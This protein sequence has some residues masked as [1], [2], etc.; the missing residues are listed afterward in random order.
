MKKW[1]R[2]IKLTDENMHNVV[3]GVEEKAEGATSYRVAK[4]G[5]FREVQFRKR[6][7]WLCK[8]S[9][10]QRPSGQTRPPCKPLH[11]DFGKEKRC[12]YRVWSARR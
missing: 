11:C 1:G 5:C 12:R 3:G 10:D 6:K 9:D 7:Q 2:W 4:E 8:Y